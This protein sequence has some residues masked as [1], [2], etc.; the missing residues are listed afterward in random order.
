[1]S[2]VK[3]L[4]NKAMLLLQDAIVLRHDGNDNIAKEKYKEAFALESKAAELVSQKNNC[5]PTRSILYRSAASLAYQSDDF[6]SSLNLIGKCLSGNP[7]PK[8]HNEIRALYENVNFKMYLNQKKMILTDEGL[9]FHLIGNQISDGLIFY[10]AFIDRIK[11]LIQIVK[12]TAQRMF[13]KPYKTTSEI[14]TPALCP[15]SGGSFSITIKLAYNKQQQRDI[16]VNPSVVVDEIID[17]F[18]YLQNEKED[19]LFLKIKDESYYN[20]FISNAKKIAPDGE[21]ISGI[22]LVSKR[23]EVNFSRLSDSISFINKN[24]GEDLQ[25]DT[26]EN[27]TL[28]GIL[29][30]AS[31]KQGKDEFA[32]VTD[33]NGKTYKIIINEGLDDYVRSYYKNKVLVEGKYDGKSMVYMNNIKQIEI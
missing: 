11:S 9:D 32:E 10:K 6:H 8:I 15:I 18:N 5:E 25:I 13:D 28:S 19:E 26:L 30:L 23:K 22:D 31:S 27:I 17:C 29:D 7:T 21:D 3:E 4:H 20:D 12:K 24:V 14:F 2:S 16:F 33:E 1:M